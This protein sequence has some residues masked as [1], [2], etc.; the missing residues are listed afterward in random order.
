MYCGLWIVDCGLMV[1]YVSVI[2]WGKISF[3]T[4]LPWLWHGFLSSLVPVLKTNNTMVDVLFCIFL[5]IQ[6]FTNTIIFVFHKV[7]NV[8]R[9]YPGLH[10]PFYEA[11]KV[12]FIYPGRGNDVYVLYLY[13]I[14]YSCSDW[15]EW[16]WTHTKERKCWS[17]LDFSWFFF[18]SSFR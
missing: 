6:G 14:R 12:I 5:S 11:L 16:K 17:G 10:L 8:N 15:R 7:Q 1:Y 9:M 13:C 18:W 4:S 3:L 2:Q